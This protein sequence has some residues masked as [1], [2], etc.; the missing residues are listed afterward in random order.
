MSHKTVA[1]RWFEEV[2]NR[3]DETAV[4]RLFAVDG[5]AHGLSPDGHDLVGPTAFIDFHRAYVGA[6]NDLRIELDDL[7]EEDD[8]VAIRWH[9]TGPHTGHGLGL[10]PHGKAMNVVG[11]SILRIHEGLIVEAWNT[12]DVLGMHQQ[13][14][15][16]G[17]LVAAR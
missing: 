2:W 11:M 13:L 7:I 15:T 5:V 8:K 16:L 1:R 6:F 10:E 14:G 9:A 12:F 4:A 17:Q 3:R